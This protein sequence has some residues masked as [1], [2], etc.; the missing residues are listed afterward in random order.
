MQHNTAGITL[1]N[2]IG[3]AGGNNCVF[4]FAIVI[5]QQA[6]NR[7]TTINQLRLC[8]LIDKNGETLKSIILKIADDNSL[9]EDFKKWIETENTFCNTLVDRIVTGYPKDE[10]IDLP[11]TDNMLNTSEL[12]HLWVI[13]GPKDILKEIPFDKT[14]FH[15]T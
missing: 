6:G 12:F 11:Y 2:F 10:K 13:E 3:N 15:R 1:S 14:G 9:G 8:E 5:D 7:Q 4:T